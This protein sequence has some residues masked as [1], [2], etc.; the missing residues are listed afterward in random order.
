MTFLLLIFL[1]FREDVSK[2]DYQLFENN[3]PARQFKKQTVNAFAADQERI[4]EI[5]ETLAREDQRV[6]RGA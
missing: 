4:H 6:V 2:T 1:L 5:Q 3:I